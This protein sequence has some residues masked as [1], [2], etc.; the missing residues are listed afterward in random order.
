M[1]GEIIRDLLARVLVGTLF[2]LMSINLLTDFIRTGRITGLL[3]LVSESLVV[4][5]TIIRRRAR[6]VD[7]SPAAAITTTL[8]L[9]GPA[10][11]RASNAH[12]LVPESL[13]VVASALGLVV[14]IAGKL[15]LGRSFGIAPA[16]RGVVV[17]GP[18]GFV[19]HPIY[20][21]YLVTHVAFIC[22]YPAVWNIAVLLV[23]DTALVLRA[24]CEERVL[25]RDR[26][27]QT[28]CRRVAWHLVPGLF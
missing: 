10:L 13:T 6:L 4:V 7:R 17:A 22:A 27:Y 19:R 16:N 11:V 12:A 20:A 14:V 21:G 23:A 3:L 18:Y 26:T 25:A 28:Y 1:S 9:I 24:L 8:S 2:F 15:T 5:L